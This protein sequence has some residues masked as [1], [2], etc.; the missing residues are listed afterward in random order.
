MKASALVMDWS[1]QVPNQ[2]Q[3]STASIARRATM[4][5]IT[6]QDQAHTT[7]VDVVIL[8]GIPGGL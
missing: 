5:T 3:Q 4:N 2:D 1:H 8:I 7:D 6:A